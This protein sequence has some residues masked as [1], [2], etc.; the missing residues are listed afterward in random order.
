MRVVVAIPSMFA[1]EPWVRAMAAA[2]PESTVSEFADTPDD[3]ADYAVVWSPDAMLFSRQQKL[4]AIFNLGAGVDALLKLPT[5]PQQLPVVRLSDAGMSVQMAEYVCQAVIRFAREIGVYESEMKEGV[6]SQRRPPSRRE[7]PVGVMGL[8]VIG[9]RVARALSVFEYPVYGWSRHAKAIEGVATFYGPLG[10][11]G[12]L[13]STRI[14]VCTL[15]LTPE[16]RGIVCRKTLEKLQPNGYLI[17]VGRGAHLVDHDLVE[18]IASGAMAGA[19]LDVFAD[20][21]LA[22]SHPFRDHPTIGLTPHI[23]AV[24]DRSES[25]RQIADKIRRFQ[26]GLPIDGV[27]ERSRGY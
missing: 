18:L 1:P 6:W 16:T 9:E 15:P 27:V 26:A 19:M 22:A 11:D 8:G 17:N 3:S 14:L 21:P 13:E 2:L 7:F 12:F 4:K 5:L 23:S 20:E 10:L 24:T 25:V